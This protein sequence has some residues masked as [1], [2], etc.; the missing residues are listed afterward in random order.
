M[1]SKNE[2]ITIG[3]CDSGSVNSDFML[4][5]TSILLNSKYKIEYTARSKGVQIAPQRQEL[6]DYWYNE[7]KTDWMLW[8]DSD[9]SIDINILEMLCSAADKQ[10]KPMVSGICFI[11]DTFEGTLPAIVPNVFNINEDNKIEPLHPLPN[12]TVTK[13]DL[14]GM[15]L[16]LMHRS[17]VTKLRKFYGDETVFFAENFSNKKDFIGEDI[18]FFTKCKEVDIPL[19]AHTGAIAAHM[20]T[21][22]WNV[23]L[24]NLFWSAYYKD[25]TPKGNQ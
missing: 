22:A 13:V 21:T 4:G 17:V 20:K 10:T 2:T 25:E 14:A 24:Y 15:G 11:T 12:N 1:I 5:I 19:Y 6:L 18:A 7:L 8:I 9:I 23:D 16:V 3:W